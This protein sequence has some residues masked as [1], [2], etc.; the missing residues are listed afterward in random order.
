MYAVMNVGSGFEKKDSAEIFFFAP[1]PVSCRGMLVSR[2]A[3][4]VFP[5]YSEVGAKR[6]LGM[7]LGCWLEVYRAGA[8]VGL[9]VVSVCYLQQA[10][11]DIS[12]LCVILP[13]GGRLQCCP[14]FCL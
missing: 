13:C 4:D 8:C 5:A 12:V 11:P 6:M 7:Y 10:C 3:S 9:L 14:H 2:N 1:F